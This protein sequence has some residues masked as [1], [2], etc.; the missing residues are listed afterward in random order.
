M[1]WPVAKR[2]RKRQSTVLATNFLDRLDKG[3]VI[4]RNKVQRTNT[5]RVT[6][7]APAALQKFKKSTE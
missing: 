5:M 7:P 4:D 1:S 2:I 3:L 6:I